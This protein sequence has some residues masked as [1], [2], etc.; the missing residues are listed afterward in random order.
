MKYRNILFDLDGTL[1]DSGPGIIACI[2]YMLEHYG[3][4]VPPAEELRVCV[5]PPLVDSFTRLFGFT[6]E[7]AHEAVGVY[8][9]RYIPIGMFENS[10]YE[11]IPSLLKGL[12]EAG[13]RLYIATSK[14]TEMARQILMHF[15][16]DGYFTQ[17]CG[18][19]MDERL[20]AKDDII[21]DLLRRLSLSEEEKAATCMVG[22]RKYDIFG[23]QK[24]GL[25]TVGVRYG[26]CEEN[27]LEEAGATYV[28]STAA[29]L[30]DFF[31]E[32]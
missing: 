10:V 21:E 16:L 8:R 28:F 4:P 25:D 22:D 23:G 1:T 30:L 3:L 9:E 26:Y 14:P 13:A 2:Q 6:E 19:S 5:G 29:Q 17:I 7:K 31:T 18:A 12:Y 20:T 32:D 15:G 11:G 24:F 27:E